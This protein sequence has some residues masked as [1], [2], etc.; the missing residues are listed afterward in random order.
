[1]TVQE[2]LAELG[3]DSVADAIQELDLA[4]DALANGYTTPA[5]PW[6][7]SIEA[8]LQRIDGEIEMLVSVS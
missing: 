7:E 1:M 6:E 4:K 3:V 8:V 5:L 2:I